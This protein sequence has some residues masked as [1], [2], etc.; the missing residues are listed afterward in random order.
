[1]A[2]SAEE[3]E[4]LGRFIESRA[5]TVFEGLL[6]DAESRKS[7]ST[8][9]NAA[10]TREAI[11]GRPDVN[12]DAGPEFYV[13]LADGSVIT[14]HDSGSTHMEADGKPVQVIGR[15]QVGA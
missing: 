12:P 13:H 4:Q 7:A 1:M 6:A 3:L 14:S 9:A 8:A 15:Y 10:A 2:L 11:V 5:A